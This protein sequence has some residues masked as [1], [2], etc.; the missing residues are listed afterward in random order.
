MQALYDKYKALT[1][2]R[3]SA[4]FTEILPQQRLLEAMRYSLLAGGKRVRPVL[5]MAFCA[6]SDGKQEDAIDFA[7]ALEML[8]TYSLIHD[9]LPC[10]DDDELRRGKP[11]NHIVFG[12]FTAV[13][14]GDALQAA[15][16]ETV[17]SSPLD[18]EKRAAAALIL[19]KASGAYGICGGQQLDMEGEDKALSISEVEDIHKLKTAALIIAAAQMGCIAAG[20]SDEK[21]KAAGE[22]ALA[23]GLA[24]Q[25]RDDLLDLES[26]TAILGKPVGSDE[27]N[28]K[29]TFV[30]L[31]GAEKCRE[32]VKL[33]TEKA[34]AALKPAFKD[35]DFLEWLADLMAGRE[36]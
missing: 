35:T 29:S 9:D 33:N 22:Y 25:I 28:E 8:H 2:E 12:E 32:L 30:S 26:T 34:K 27:G 4:A 15:A 11:T 36:S 17:L 7:A 13:L 6:A 31:L 10:M 5:V 21:L 3:L 23:L 18:A 1:E 16:F 14:A 20:A 24:F 19:A